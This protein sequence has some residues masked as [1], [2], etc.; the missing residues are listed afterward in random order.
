M[1]FLSG[2][3]MSSSPER[4][5]DDV[6][7]LD[8]SLRETLRYAPNFLERPADEVGWLLAAPRCV[9]LGAGLF[10]RWRIAAIMAKASMTSETW[11]CQPCQDLVSLWSRP[12]SFLAVSK[13]SSIAQRWPSTWPSVSIA[14]P[15]GPRR[16]DSSR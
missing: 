12:N 13:L 10:A 5:C 1:E 7:G 16:G 4:P 15:A 3:L 11:R 9:F 14:A 2:G 6:G 8:A